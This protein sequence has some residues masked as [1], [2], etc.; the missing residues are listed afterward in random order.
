LLDIDVQNT[1]YSGLE[2]LTVISAARVVKFFGSGLLF[3]L[4]AVHLS[5][6]DIWNGPTFT[7]DPAVLRQAAA[8][9][10]PE[11]D[12]EATVLLSAVRF[13]FD[14]A[15][16]L[17]ES[18][19]LIYRIENQEGV[20]EWAEISGRWESWH[21]TRPEIK[22][23]VITSE[24]AVHELDPKTLSDLPVHENAPD[25]YSDERKYG[26]PL[27]ALAPGSI[28]E[29]E[30]VVHDT[31]PLFSAGLVR[32]WICAWGAPVN[33]TQV[34]LVHPD[35]IPIYFQ[36]H[37]LP[38]ATTTK[39][40]ENGLETI[41]LEQG[42]LPAFTEQLDHVPPDLVSYPEIEFSTSTSW[43]QVAAEYARLSEEKLRL[44]DVQSLVAKIDLKNG[45]RN[46]AIRR[47]VA[48]L[49]KNVRYTGVEFGESSLIP[50][51]PAE[52]LKR[53]YGDC[54]D[55]ATLL[56]AMLHSAGIPAS[57]ALLSTGPGREINPDLPGMGMFD[58]AIVFVPGSSSDPELW[59]DATAEYSQ[60]GTLPWMDYGRWALVVSEKTKSLKQIPEITS[61]QNVR[62]EFREFA[63]AEYG[64]AKIVE[65][66][67]ETGPE[68]ADYRSYYSGDSKQLRERSESYVKEAYLAD[69]LTALEHG[70]L[71]DLEKPASVKFITKGR[72]GTTDLTSAT[73]AIRLEDLFESLPKYF[74]TKEEDKTADS[75]SSDKPKPR[76]A[77]WWITPFTTE[78]RYKVTAP[79]GFKVRAVPSDKDEKV[80]TLSFTQKYSTNQ[81]GTMVEAVLRVENDRTRLTVDQAMELRDAVVRARNSD[82]IFITFDH[83]GHSLLLSGKIKEG[84]AAYEQVAALH[85]KEALHKV[86]LAEALLMAGLAEE[87]RRVAREGTALEPGSALGFSTLA[88][89]LKNDLIGRP[90]KKGMDY[91]GAVAAYRKAVT[92]DPKDKEMRANLA[93]LLEYDEDGTRYSDKALLKEAVMELRE[94]KK[95]DEQYSRTYDDN[96]L[97]DLW[98]AHDYKGVLDYAATVPT[99]EVRK[100][101]TLGA[102]ALL[103]GSDAAVKKSLEITTD[104]ESRGKVLVNAGTVLVRVRKYAEAS[105]LLSA[106][107]RGHSNESQIARSAA[108]FSKTKPYEELKMDAADPRSVVQ[109]LFGKML[110]GQL[111]IEEY[112]SFVYV[113]SKDPEDAMDE[114]KFQQ[115]MSTLK[116]QT[117]STG[118]PL[119]NIA[120]LA[121]SNMHY[122][123]EGDDTLGY[124]IIVESPGAAAQN[125]FVVRDDG[126]YKIAGFAMSDNVVPEE[127]AP[128]A[129][130]EIENNN[131]A[132]A[133]TWLDRA[134]DEI[135]ITGGDDPLAGQPFP[136]FWTKGQEADVSAIRTATL[137]LLP[138][139]KLKGPYLSALIQA[140]DAAKTDQERS[141]L[142]MVLAYAH[143]AQ[144]HW[145]EMLPLAEEL[146]KE[147]P[148][149]VRAYD[150]AVT[151]YRPLKRFDEWEKL[152]QARMHQYPDELAYVRSSSELAIYRGQFDRARKIIKVL[153]DKGQATASDMN[154]YAWYA[155]MV[156]A[157]VDQDA[158]DVG[159]RAN[160]LTKNDNF[161]IL[162]TL[163][164]VYAE[165]GKT[166]QARELLLKAMEALHVEEPNSEIWFGFASIAEQYGSFDAAEAMYR[167]VEKPQFDYPGTSY[168]ISQQ[169]LAGL[170]KNLT[171]TAKSAGQ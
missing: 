77:D 154:L 131:L 38:D 124:K 132:A 108:I 110:S 141:R 41:T 51:F 117:V 5:A 169:R 21:Q 145:A 162:H 1:I 150:L 168:V 138:S 65:T 130:R 63:M 33:K 86:Q 36:V 14:E 111:K 143:A 94:L 102:I 101:L 166:S 64:N 91:A 144:K 160:D 27:P 93:L 83:V 105:A 113:D 30:I 92:L 6:T 147:F 2:V 70:D 133:R 128:L 90:L 107:A 95:I 163:A 31:S 171:A 134:R 22:A 148:T 61:T 54:K 157:P 52:T 40:K 7:T 62:R 12:A 146:M 4:G 137:V 46:D 15:G 114:K 120:D 140:R 84:L 17:E 165:A 88:E 10:Q 18:R 78:W 129:L 20:K 121:V 26:G 59:I 48:A 8:A 109:Q 152:N 68:E 74:K 75:E 89:V 103:Q 60:L 142:T 25:M 3:L 125:F 71:S 135:H 161:A 116:M 37:L 99:S 123:L 136:H 155:L 170:R 45:S 106:G 55:K 53:K 96:V 100:G 151:A 29:E 28:V 158:I 24:G 49:H 43:Q 13:Q 50:Q 126:H 81:E 80:G 156:S 115:M 97:Y 67:E 82:A 58:H 47:I 76:T 72:R 73:M 57:L 23:R 34:V 44:A 79:L 153:L 119:V 19:H 11:K 16:K 35:S 56:V 42:P 164:C 39:S 87:S 98:Y 66:D 104:D 9:I 127:L 122:T 118:L 32:R 139:K 112:K 149:S 85:P 69:S 159:V 167:R